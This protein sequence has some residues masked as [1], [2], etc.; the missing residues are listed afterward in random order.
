MIQFD[1]HLSAPPHLVGE[2]QWLKG[3]QNPINVWA[4]SGIPVNSVEGW[5]D[6]TVGTG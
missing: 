6:V 5:C 4:S 1:T 2:L 3:D